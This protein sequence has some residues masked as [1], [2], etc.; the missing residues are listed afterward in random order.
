MQRF[1][2]VDKSLRSLIWE[3]HKSFIFD[4]K[5]TTAVPFKYVEYCELHVNLLVFVPNKFVEVHDSAL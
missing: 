3:K 2:V 4:S 5:H 1:S